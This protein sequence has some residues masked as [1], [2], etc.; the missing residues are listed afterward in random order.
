MSRLFADPTPPT[1]EGID[2]LCADV[3]EALRITRGARLVHA[4]PP[5]RYARDA[6]GANPEQN[7]IYDAL[8]EAEI[9]AHLDAAYDCAGPSARLVCWYTWPKAAEWRAAGHA[10]RRWG[11]EVSG[12]AWLKTHQVG[13]GF[14]WRGAS[15]PIAL[16]TK[17][18][19]GRPAEVLLNG[20]A[21]PPG[22]HSEKP[23]E[24][25][26]AMLRAWT[27]PGDLV[28]DLYAGRAPMARACRLEGRRYVGAEIDAVRHAAACSALATVRGA[29]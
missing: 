11:A 7:G 4:D 14:H 20:H 3:A 27:S 15:E 9:V 25:L 8:S 13:V 10:G 1:F 12:G 26:R 17:G 2:L 23:L 28:L 24:W 19:T 5:W 18:A 22:A 21:S 6:G 29:A 16:F